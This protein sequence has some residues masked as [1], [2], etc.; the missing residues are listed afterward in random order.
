MRVHTRIRTSIKQVSFQWVRKLLKS[1]TTSNAG[2][3]VNWKCRKPEIRKAGSPGNRKV[4]KYKRSYQV[5]CHLRAEKEYLYVHTPWQTLAARSKSANEYSELFDKIFITGRWGANLSEKK[6]CNC[7]IIQLGFCYG[8]IKFQFDFILRVKV[9]H[10]DLTL[11]RTRGWRGEGGGGVG[12]HPSLNPKVFL[13]FLLGDKTSA[14]DVFS[15]CF[16]IPCAHFGSNSVTLRNGA[17]RSV[18]PAKSRVPWLFARPQRKPMHV[19]SFD[20]RLKC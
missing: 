10:L 19:A 8:S 15:R 4:R 6:N 13:S 1:T 17:C 11:G 16:F 7:L 5:C 14:P 3:H 9:R 18:S 20:S 12:C 2:R